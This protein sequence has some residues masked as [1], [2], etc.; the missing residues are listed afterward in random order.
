MTVLSARASV[1]TEASIFAEKK[2]YVVC[3]IE[4]ERNLRRR[5]RAVGACS[6]GWEIC[7]RSSEM[8]ADILR[9]DLY[10]ESRNTLFLINLH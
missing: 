9:A 3:N 4:N 1:G 5:A 8:S 2:N 10:P 7:G 6:Y